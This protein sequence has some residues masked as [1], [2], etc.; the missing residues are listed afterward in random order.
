MKFDFYIELDLMN[1]RISDTFSWI[2][3]NDSIEFDFI[4]KDSI[5]SSIESGQYCRIKVDYFIELNRMNRRISD[6]LN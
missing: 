6:T 4:N 2:K 1:R 3:W 5:T